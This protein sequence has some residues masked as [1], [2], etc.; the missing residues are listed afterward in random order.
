MAVAHNLGFPRIGTTR[1]LK[2]ALE[3]FWHRDIDDAQL[4]HA[5]VQ[6][7]RQHWLLQRDSGMN[8]IPCGDFA[9]S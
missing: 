3:S 2:R 9:L 5:A 6:L 4:L 8:Q 1:E 7:R